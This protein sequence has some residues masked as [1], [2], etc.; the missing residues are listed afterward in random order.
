MLLVTNYRNEA[1]KF[2]YAENGKAEAAFLAI[3]KQGW[4][5][6]FQKWDRNVDPM[7]LRYHFTQEHWEMAT[8][9]EALFNQL[10]EGMRK[11]A[12]G[13][14][15][16]YR[17]GMERLNRKVEMLNAAKKLVEA[18]KEDALKMTTTVNGKKRPLVV[19]VAEELN[20]FLKDATN[21]GYTATE[22]YE[23]RKTEKY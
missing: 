10:P 22:L 11:L 14:R 6:Y 2:Y 16:R 13:H 23:I 21:D 20:E 8:M 7:A 4:K 1:E 5:K 3:L 9:D 18:P 19:V 17:L 15:N 12:A